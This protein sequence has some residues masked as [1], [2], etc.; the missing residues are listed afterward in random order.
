MPLTFGLSRDPYIF[1]NNQDAKNIG[2]YTDSI[3]FI[4][5]TLKIIHRVTLSL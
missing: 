4:F 3:G 1:F 5:N 2:A